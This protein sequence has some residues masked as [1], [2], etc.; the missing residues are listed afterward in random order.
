MYA[1][2]KYKKIIILT[3]SIKFLTWK[4]AHTSSNFRL[5]G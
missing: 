3:A 4:Q 2:Q 5:S 1:S